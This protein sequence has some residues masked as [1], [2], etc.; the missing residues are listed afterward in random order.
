MIL[1]LVFTLLGWFGTSMGADTAMDVTM[2]ADT[3]EAMTEDVAHD[4]SIAADPV[5]S[6]EHTYD[7]IPVST[8]L[9]PGAVAIFTGPRA[10][11]ES[12]P[13]WGGVHESGMPRFNT[14][15]ELPA[16]G[17]SWSPEAMIT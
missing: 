15:F 8:P 4:V 10:S 1:P 13:V 12:I 3:A 11:H 2:E 7:D 9:G 6:K 16:P 5:D 17:D 14:S